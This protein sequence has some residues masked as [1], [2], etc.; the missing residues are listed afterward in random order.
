M[1]PTISSRGIDRRTLL[2][3][4]AVLPASSGLAPY[5]FRAGANRNTG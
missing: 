2:A 1:K 3:A 5:R 4:L